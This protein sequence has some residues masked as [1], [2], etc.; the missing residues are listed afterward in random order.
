VILVCALLCGI[1]VCEAGADEVDPRKEAF[2]G[3]EFHTNKMGVVDALM[4]QK[5]LT[6]KPPVFSNLSH[7]LD[8][9]Q[10]NLS[11]D[12]QNRVYELDAMFAPS[13]PA[14]FPV[15]QPAH[16]RFRMGV[17]IELE[18]ESSF[19]ADFSPEFSADVELPNMEREW[20]IFITTSDNDELP[21]RQITEL[22]GETQLGISRFWKRLGVRTSA[23]IKTRIPPEAFVK[24]Q[25]ADSYDWGKWLT[26]PYQKFFWES[27]DGAGSLT[28]LSFQRWINPHDKIWVF[29]STSAGL[30]SEA[31]QGMEIEQTLSM[32]RFKEWIEEEDGRRLTSKYSA[33]HAW[34]VF[35]S[36]FGHLDEDEVLDKHRV[37]FVYRRPVYKRWMFLEVSPQLEWENGN[38]W[39]T[40]PIIR[41]GLDALFWGAH[42]P[43]QREHG[44]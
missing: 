31:S 41:V 19:K 7:R 13:R 42:V 37:G 11:Y 34:G 2:L 18:A 44:N 26:V 4:T 9:I 29:R 25:W 35:Y 30:I 39:D 17:Y 23:G 6:E 15:D 22:D 43:Q 21:G 8:Y 14:D 20:R 24:A 12:L 10:D 36:A 1:L 3:T 38:D 28:S 33:A 5:L 32:I 16:S 40:E 27:D